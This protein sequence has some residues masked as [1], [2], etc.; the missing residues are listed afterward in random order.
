[1]DKLMTCLSFKCFF[2]IFKELP[3]CLFE[4]ILLSAF[5]K[6]HKIPFK[7]E[8]NPPYW[9]NIPSHSHQS[10]WNLEHTHLVNPKSAKYSWS[11]RMDL[12]EQHPTSHCAHCFINILAISLRPVRLK[13][14]DVFGMESIGKHKL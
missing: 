7:D 2:S 6:Q 4:T 9:S 1:M 5:L 11:R 3:F 13:S 14:Q 12:R 8:K 10:P